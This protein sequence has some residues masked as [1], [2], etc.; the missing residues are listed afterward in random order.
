MP[1]RY[2]Y[3]PTEGGQPPYLVTGKPTSA[4]FASVR[5]GLLQVVRL[6]DATCLTSRG[7][8]QSLGTGQLRT[9]A[10]SGRLHVPPAARQATL[11]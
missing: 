7:T 1:V 2:L 5:F 10:G 9:L 8:W 6:A 11:R 3:F 4:D